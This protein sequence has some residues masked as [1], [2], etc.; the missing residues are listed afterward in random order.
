MLGMAFAA[1]ATVTSTPPPLRDYAVDRWTT[2][3]GLSHNSIRGMAQSTDGY[4]WFG[5][6]EGVVRYNGQ[7]FVVFD[8]ASGAGL[9]D[10]G[11]GAL[12]R[13]P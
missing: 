3:D 4:L 12:Y 10:N 9:L 5:S 7:E 2:A 13:D 6:W 1:N 8:R 11:I